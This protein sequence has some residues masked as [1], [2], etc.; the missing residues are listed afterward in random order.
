MGRGR[1]GSGR[2]RSSGRGRGRY[3]GRVQHAT[4]IKGK[5][6]SGLS[7]ALGKAMFT[8]GEKNSAKNMRTTWEKAVQHIG[9]A[10]GQDISMEFRTRMLMMI[11]E[12][13]KS[14]EILDR[15]W[16]KI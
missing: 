1:G 8:Y 6:K 13:I 10:L 7:K 15:Y 4:S 11:P 9:I 12:P 3:V 14:Q 2:G 5:G 16:R